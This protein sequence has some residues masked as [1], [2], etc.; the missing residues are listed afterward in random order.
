MQYYH[1]TCYEGA[2]ALP[3][4][5]PDAVVEDNYRRLS[6]LRDTAHPGPIYIY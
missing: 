6:R 5:V 2:R 4:R 1:M 3:P